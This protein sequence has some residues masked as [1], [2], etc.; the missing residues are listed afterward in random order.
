MELFTGPY[1][2]QMKTAMNAMPDEKVIEQ[3]AAVDDEL[4]LGEIGAMLSGAFLAQGVPFIDARSL[5][6]ELLPF[7][8]RK[9]GL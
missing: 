6:G 7:A 4:T 8:V 9:T 1:A 5:A 2:K 3:L